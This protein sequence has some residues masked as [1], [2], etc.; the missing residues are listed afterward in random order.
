KRISPY[1]FNFGTPY[2]GTCFPRDTAAFI[3]FA[4]NRN[5]DAKH[6]KFAD[7]VNEAA[8]AA[9]SADDGGEA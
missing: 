3:K 5:K 9:P 7:E 6:L 8:E 4:S 2:G 1:F